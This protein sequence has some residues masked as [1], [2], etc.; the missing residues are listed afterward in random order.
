MIK[1]VKEERI[2]HAIMFSG[3]KGNGA[4]PLAIAFASYIQCKGEKEEDKCG[5]CKACNKT[6]KLIHPDINFIFPSISTGSQS[7]PCSKYINEW[8]NTVLNKTFFDINDWIKEINA[9]S[10]N[11]NISSATIMELIHYYS[12]KKFEGNKKISIIW[13]AELMKEQGNKILKL[14]E[15]PPEDSLFLFI[16][17]NIEKILPTILSR[18]R[19]ITVP[20]FEDK[21][22]IN[23]AKMQNYN[24]PANELEEIANIAEG[25][26]EEF[27]KMLN[28]NTNDFYSEFLTWMR[29]NYTGNSYDLFSYIDGFAKKTKENQK[30]FF[31]YGLKFMEKVFKSFY[32]DKDN[33]NALQEEYDSI[34]KIKKLLDEEKAL[35]IIKILN[36]NIYFLE[37]N[38]NVKVM[39]YSTSR[40]IHRLL[41]DKVTA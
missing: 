24:I 26:M 10:K 15:E 36:D 2:P 6:S 9:E 34:L 37:R 3:P 12:L 39:M 30:Y 40:Q 29:L 18:C 5:Q 35:K 1:A 41:R 16:T 20:P 4:L 23:W 25:D 7:T 28:H 32:L 17:N 38:A 11:A 14:I 19:I 21:D 8:R 27:I 33:I 31:K 13:Q 22:L